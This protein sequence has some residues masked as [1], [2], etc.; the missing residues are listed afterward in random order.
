M[1]ISYHGAQCFK[2]SFGDTTLAFDPISRASTLKGAKFGA[3][4]AFISLN[5][6]D[7]NGHE[8]ATLGD[9]EP[10][11]ISGPG[12]YEISG[13][14]ARGIASVSTYGGV[15]RINTIYM[16]TFEGMKLCFMGAHGQ[17][18]LPQEVKSLSDDIDILFLPIGGNGV[19][20]PAEAHKL[21]VKLEPKIIIPMHFGDIGEKGALAEFLKEEGS[22]NTKPLD[23]LTL[24]KKDLDGKQGEVIVLSQ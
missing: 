18:D 5:H 2:V 3:D 8:Q 23:K 6:P 19:L 24:K 4:I 12:E 15:E 11:V 20:T 14:F 7:M 10:V 17:P 21:A 13:I 1:I 22:E 16:L 9:R